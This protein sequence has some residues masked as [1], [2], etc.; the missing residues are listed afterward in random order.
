[1][2]A[3][4]IATFGRSPCWAYS[5]LLIFSKPVQTVNSIS[6][7]ISIMNCAFH[8]GPRAFKQTMNSISEHVS[9]MACLL[10]G[11]SNVAYDTR[12]ETESHRISKQIS[13][14]NS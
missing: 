4:G 12:G 2:K 10:C 7:H 5:D 14:T 1:V 8:G 13:L 3:A 6:E 9:I 11:I